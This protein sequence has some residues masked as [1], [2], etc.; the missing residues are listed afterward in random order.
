MAII[1]HKDQNKER[2][3]SWIKYLLR[4]IK[5]NKNNL[6]AVIGKTGSGKTWSA[7]SVCELISKENGVYFGIENIVFNLRKLMELINSGKLKKGSC[8]IFDEPQVTISAREWQS[9]TNR[10][11]NY[12]LSTF[13]HRNLTLFFCSPYEDLL[14]KSTRKLFHAKFQTVKINFNDK[15]CELRPKIMEYNSYKQ[16]FYEKFLRIAFKPKDK[17]SYVTK[18]LTSWDIPKPSGDLIKVYEEKKLAFTTKLNQNILRDLK[19]EE[20][21]KDNR[22]ELTEIQNKVLKLL[23][24][25]KGNVKKVAKEMNLSI[26]VI[27]FH[28]RQIKKKGYDV[29]KPKSLGN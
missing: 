3:N 24:N 16:K 25:Y 23:G 26:Q 20:L 10:V 27:Y 13:R 19:V 17:T 15:T 8:I 28:I 1:I 14:D 9:K 29:Y 11:F 22:K 4:R 21:K 6:I 5:Q 18:K 7:I 2:K 12:L